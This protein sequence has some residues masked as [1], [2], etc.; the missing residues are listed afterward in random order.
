MRVPGPTRNQCGWH[1]SAGGVSVP[2]VPEGIEREYAVGDVRRALTPEQA[3]DPRWRAEN[4]DAF[5]TA[6]FQRR[7][8][9]D[10]ASLGNNGAVEGRH[11][12]AGKLAAPG[13]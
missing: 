8:E 7:R 3:T 13:S 5:W 10:L 11:R 1:L 9:E 12:T 4:N 2:P 6:Y